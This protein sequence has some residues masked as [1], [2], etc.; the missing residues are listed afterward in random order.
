ME[1]GPMMG[2]EQP[3]QNKLYYT[4][5]SLDKRVR[6]DHP[7]RR[8]SAVVDFDFIYEEVSDKYG[9]NGN[10]SV[11]PPV[12]L[13]LMLLLVLYNVRSERELMV[14]LP[15]RLDWLWF[16]GYDLDSEI[17]DHSVLSKARRRWGVEAFR[18]FFQRIVWQC[19]RAGLV[20]GSRI[21][22]DSSLVHAD[23]SLDSVVDLE[24]LK[25]R[26][27]AG[28]SAIEERLTEAR[29]PRGA[30]ARGRKVNK[31][32]ISTTDPDS[33]IV[34]QG[35]RKLAYAVH[36]S[37]DE[38]N[39]VITATST[40]AGDVNEAHHLVDLLETHHLNT[41]RSARAVVGDTK[42]GTVDNYLHCHERGI[43]AHMQPM[44]RTS[45]TDRFSRED[46]I[47]DAVS[48]QYICPAGQRLFRAG[49]DRKRQTY[50]YQ[51]RAA[52][53]RDCPIR[54]GC[55]QSKSGRKLTRHFRQRELEVALREAGSTRSKVDIAKRQHLMERSFAQ[56]KRHG[57][58]RARW[59]G[60]CHVSIQQYLVAAVQNIR[61]L[62]KKGD[63]PTPVVAVEQLR[64]VLPSI[65][66]QYLPGSLLNWLSMV[67]GI[68]SLVLMRTSYNPIRI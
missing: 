49:V 33:S 50:N 48:D 40:T 19:V 42:Y 6:C 59:R 68:I 4:S 21:F 54:S 26:I 14:T 16:L 3:G 67:N 35:G 62:V 46:F 47:Y 43:A 37:V 57:Y 56:G 30:R 44:S 18:S 66:G 55:T 39:E 17:P 45:K 65:M 58:K 41:G 15:E 51:A 34:A 23:A 29:E 38:S 32:F 61:I 8:V 52:A 27:R 31:R 5:F 13:K 60:L 22:V 12:I 2:V 7:L 24:S 64:S 53:C 25:G 10:V 36:R 28:I 9:I 11:P 63:L 1:N 20:D